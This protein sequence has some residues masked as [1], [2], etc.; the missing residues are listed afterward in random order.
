M[1]TFE[2]ESAL[3]K[4]G[5]L[6]L[7]S[8]KSENHVNRLRNT[9]L[10]MAF[11]STMIS[12]NGASRDVAIYIFELIGWIWLARSS[13]LHPEIYK[14]YQT[15]EVS[16]QRKILWDCSDYL[17]QWKC[18]ELQAGRKLTKLALTTANKKLILCPLDM[19]RLRKIKKIDQFYDEFNRASLYP[20]ANNEIDECQFYEK[21]LI[22]RFNPH[23]NLYVQQMPHIFHVFA[24]AGQERENAGQKVFAFA[25]KGSIISTEWSSNG[26]YLLV[27]RGLPNR[28]ANQHCINNDTARE[29]L[30]FK[31]CSNKN[32]MNEIICNP[33]ILVSGTQTSTCLWA[34]NSSFIVPMG[35]DQ[36]LLLAKIRKNS[37]KSE[38]I[39]THCK[40]VRFLPILRNFS[41]KYSG[42]FFTGKQYGAL[43]FWI[44]N[45]IENVIISLFLVILNNFQIQIKL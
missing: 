36:P 14:F 15:L 38:F 9:L 4:V 18:F 45:C 1:F 22:A 27:T 29:I 37:I 2:E 26:L 17:H 31:Y 13:V 16:Q 19:I 7:K 5:L 12:G 43:I 32:R 28:S 3:K 44:T 10:G 8:F 33:R 30:I 6:N 23:Y 20:S 35:L 40:N 25:S 11:L 24:F 34:N 39:F 42:C 41:T 21:H